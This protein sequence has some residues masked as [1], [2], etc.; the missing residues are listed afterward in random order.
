MSE[1][2]WL[3]LPAQTRAFLEAVLIANSLVE[4]REN[5]QLNTTKQLIKCI[6]QN[7]LRFI[8]RR[9]WHSARKRGAG[10]LYSFKKTTR[11][12]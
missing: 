2:S 3:Q 11:S 1:E 5:M 6:E 8:C 4:I 10:L 9:S 7:K 12:G